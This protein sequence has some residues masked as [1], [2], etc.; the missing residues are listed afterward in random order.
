MIINY[1]FIIYFQIIINYYLIIGDISII[2]IKF[3]YFISNY[4]FLIKVHRFT[5]YSL[6]L[7]LKFILQKFNLNL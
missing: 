7:N 3:K 6:N 2:L 5:I 4:F 1:K